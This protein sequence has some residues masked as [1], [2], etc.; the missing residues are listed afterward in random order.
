[1]TRDEFIKELTNC[2][3]QVRWCLKNYGY[4]KKIRTIDGLHCPISWVAFCKGYDM[5][6][7]DHPFMTASRLGMESVVAGEIVDA[8][9]YE[10]VEVGIRNQLLKAVKLLPQA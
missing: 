9:D 1:M 3:G 10:D 7:K 4:D 6:D 2:A 8:A 5:C